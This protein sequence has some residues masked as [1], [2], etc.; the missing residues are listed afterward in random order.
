MFAWERGAHLPAAPQPLEP[1]ACLGV[2]AVTNAAT[3]ACLLV[4]RM[5]DGLEIG[6]E[7]AGR[8]LAN[9]LARGPPHG[10][11]RGDDA[12][13]LR[14]AVLRGQPLEKI[15]GVGCEADRKR[16]DLALLPHAVE[17]DHTP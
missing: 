7:E 6:E 17:A 4:I 12:H 16:S 8:Q 13:E 5:T 15:V 11:V 14:R 3:G 1:L 2:E 10:R 9:L